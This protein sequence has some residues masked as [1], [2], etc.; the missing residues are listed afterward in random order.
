MYIFQLCTVTITKI[1]YLYRKDAVRFFSF[2][3][4]Y[5][6]CL[7]FPDTMSKRKSSEDKEIEVR[8][9]IYITFF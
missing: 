5:F 4:L 1:S 9:G 7:Y 3:Y 6:F 8:T 2:L